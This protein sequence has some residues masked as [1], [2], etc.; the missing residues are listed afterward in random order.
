MS[1]RL[2]QRESAREVSYR[3]QIRTGKELAQRHYEGRIDSAISMVQSTRTAVAHSSEALK[4]TRAR[5]GETVRH[6]RTRLQEQL[7]VQRQ[8]A[9]VA[10]AVAAEEMKRAE[11]AS[12]AEV[13]MFN[14][15]LAQLSSQAAVG[16]GMLLTGGGVR[17]G[18]LGAEWAKPRQLNHL[19]RHHATPPPPRYLGSGDDETD[20]DG[21]TDGAGRRGFVKP[22]QLFAALDNSEHQHVRGGDGRQAVAEA[23]KA[24][25][26]A[27][28]NSM[29][30]QPAPVTSPEERSRR[31]WARDHRQSAAARP[32]RAQG[33][34]IWVRGNGVTV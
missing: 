14:N 19:P 29:G 24:T 17:A 16:T 5:G 25:A 3:A 8:E 21:D 2:R 23:Y 30:Y 31:A 34:G 6:A 13:A 22:E 10:K 11:S 12:E 1:A 33:V 9:A 28:L 32:R 26:A 27:R 20:G 18:A 7:E 4:S 15:C